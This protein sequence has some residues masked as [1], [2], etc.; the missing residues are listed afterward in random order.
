MFKN[1]GEKDQQELAEFVQLEQQKAS[2]QSQVIFILLT[3]ARTLK[4]C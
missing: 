4:Y 2:Y 1:L 3:H